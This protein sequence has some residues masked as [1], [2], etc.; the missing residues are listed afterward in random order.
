MD[1]E[2]TTRRTLKEEFA[3][4]LLH[5][6]FDDAV[7]NLTGAQP[8]TIRLV[9]KASTCWRLNKTPFV[10]I[11]GDGACYAIREGVMKKYSLAEAK[12]AVEFHHRPALGEKG[13]EH[14]VRRLLLDARRA[15]IKAR[16]EQKDAEIKKARED[17]ANE[18]ARL[19]SLK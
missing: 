10:L 19:K 18:V 16:K 3:D 5:I 1:S 6:K 2:G 14:L 17:C 9:R 8:S 12:A 13:F 4:L 11:D 7:V 15:T